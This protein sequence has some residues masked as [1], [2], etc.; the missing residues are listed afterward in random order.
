MRLSIAKWN[1]K[2]AAGLAAMVAA[3]WC[4]SHGHAE[5]CTP[6]GLPD[7]VEPA[8]IAG[9][10]WNVLY[11]NDSF[12]D[13]SEAGDY[14]STAWADKIGGIITGA[15]DRQTNDW[16][17][18][19]PWFTGLPD[20]DLVVFDSFDTG[21]NNTTCVTLD[22]PKMRCASDRSLRWVISHEMF[23]GIQR[24][25]EVNGGLDGG[26]GF[27]SWYTEGTARCL[28]DRY[29]NE[30]DGNGPY[31]TDSNRLMG[32]DDA[33]LGPYRD[34][35]LTQLSYRGCLFWGYCCEQ[36][37]SVNVEPDSGID[38][39][40]TLWENTEA[41]LIDSGSKDAI[42]SMRR[43]VEE[44]SGRPLDTFFQDYTICLYAREFD[45]T[46]L[47]N[48]SRYA[49]VDENAG[50]AGD[51][52]LDNMVR[53]FTH[54]GNLMIPQSVLGAT[55]KSYGQRIGEVT[56]A[57]PP[58]TGVP[59]RVVGVR[60]TS[61]QDMGWSVVAVKNDD[62]AAP[63]EAIS[64]SKQ[65]GKEYA[66]AFL[67]NPF[68]PLTRLGLIF[69]GF[70]ED[71]SFNYTV[72]TGPAT[73]SIIRPTFT[74]PAYPGPANNP[75]RMLVR[76]YV[77]GPDNLKPSDVV[78]QVSI[79]GLRKE[80]FSVTIGAANAP[81][82]TAGY[83]GGEYWL[84][85]D[86]PNQAADGLYDVTV[87][88]CPDAP[89]GPSDSEDN[90][91]VYADITLNHVLVIDRSGSMGEPEDGPINKLDAAKNA[92]SL[93]VDAVKD[94]DRIAVVR[95][96]GNDMECDDDANTSVGLGLANA[97]Q[98]TNARNAVTGLTPSGW[99][100]IGDGLWK[101]QDV[102]DGFGLTDMDVK[103]IVLLS[104]GEENEARFWAKTGAVNCGAGNTLDD[105]VDN[106]IV[107]T[108]TVVNSIAF[109]PESNQALMQDIATQT[110]GDYSYIE[111]TDA[112]AIEP[113]TSGGGA[114]SMISELA[115][116]Y[117]KKLQ[118]AG[119]L[120]RIFFESGMAD[121]GVGTTVIIPVEEGGVDEAEFFVNW[122]VSAGAVTVE[123]RNPGGVL[124][125]AAQAT[126]YSTPTHTVFH[127]NAVLGTGSW[128][129]DIKPAN[130]SEFIVGLL[131]K[132][133]DGPA[134][135]ADVVQ[136]Q[137]G[138]LQG[139]PNFGKFER[140]VPVVIIAVLTTNRGGIAGA[141]VEATVRRPDGTQACG[142]LVLRDDGTQG[143]GEADD[144][145]YAAVFT[146]TGQAGS[147][148]GVINDDPG[149]TSP[150]GTVG[151]YRVDIIA[152]G[153]T[154]QGDTFGRSARA[155]F[156]I[157]ET[158]RN[159]EDEDGLPDTWE[160]YYG[161]NLT[162]NDASKD[163]DDDGLKHIEEF[164]HGTDPFDQDT[165]DG[166]ESDG[167]E[168]MGGRCPLDPG[169]DLLPCPEDVG[170]IADTG[171]LD[172]GVLI[173]LANLLYFPV[174]PSYEFMRIFR[175]DQ[176]SPANFVMVAQLPINGPQDGTH[177]DMNL[178][179]GRTYFY[180]FQAVGI[181]GATSC[182]SNIV[183]AKA[184][185]HPVAPAGW[186]QLNSGAERTDRAAALVALNL[187][188]GAGWYRIK[189]GPFL[190]VDPFLPVPESPYLNW[191]L[192]LPPPGGLARVFVQ[193]KDT[194]TGRTSEVFEETIVYDPNGN[195]DGAG[196]PN[197]LDADDDNDGVSDSDEIFIYHTDAYKVDTDEDG[198]SDGFEANNGCLNAR[199]PDTDGDGILDGADD[200]PAGDDLDGDGMG[201]VLDYGK[202]QMCFTGPGGGPVSPGCGCA[203]FDG[204]DDVDLDDW[205]A[206]VNEGG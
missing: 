168:V 95:F 164:K 6:G 86:A 88:L 87:R 37:G 44:E 75:G 135:V 121:G 96:S 98:R 17:F 42:G 97:G 153:S 175:S 113:G 102:L 149:N 63:E 189:N 14:F 177:Y 143:D 94:S 137:T 184:Y 200:L 155:Y 144:G 69:T 151:T 76:V 101:A 16:N 129:V 199:N 81:I 93:Y 163:P 190:A 109:G 49:F 114:L 41:D 53:S 157:Y 185:A 83:V 72:D 9:V 18:D 116:D 104:D 77:D 140:G 170:V 21:T 130:D 206:Y 43:T 167:S 112:G 193:Y 150:G 127:M 90:A 7:M 61:D 29:D 103:Q 132:Q 65:Q 33:D 91:V 182:K 47:P 40:R 126:I 156:H 106:R 117:M 176:N 36:L 4:A 171:D 84:V 133:K 99:T 118:K 181:K 2:T 100:S 203:D 166:G 195:F 23:H 202:F 62:G 188:T 145:I 73:I 125:T 178:I 11:T 31:I 85:V 8:T 139:I 56:F 1:V 136:V 13:C 108:D 141:N 192:A 120:E 82:V 134:L 30:L 5:T 142:V 46:A 27:G 111:V 198:R 32:S 179:D 196:L 186:L 67:L 28:D 201:T 51:G 79:L 183:R 52:P 107:P 124:V 59:C 68:S 191:N 64:L 48:P 22:A 19:S 71:A 162:V 66:R 161:T 131:G 54:D 123:L 160:K 159:D 105:R 80:D 25:Y 10:D 154:S 78:G 110:Q 204:D 74:R 205:E 45:A 197:F 128:R 138:G 172:E 70:G 147:D 39:I 35:S 187:A 146:D 194:A 89:N 180:K 60:G 15:A 55:V 122:P 174:H 12:L 34:L 115:D 119:G 20:V 57:G 3:V 92:A 158:P 58:I 148:R 173:P 24:R 152:D 50:N 38:F 169:D 165:D 26:L